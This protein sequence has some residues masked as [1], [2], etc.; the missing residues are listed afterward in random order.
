VKLDLDLVEVAQGILWRFTYQSAEVMARLPHGRTSYTHIEDGLL[1]MR[2]T[3]GPGGAGWHM[4]ART[5]AATGA[6]RHLLHAPGAVLRHSPAALL[7]KRAAK[8][9]AGTLGA[10]AERA[11]WAARSARSV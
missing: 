8:H 3:A 11:W 6:V 1:S 7:L 5:H 2:H 9:A 10:A 4:V